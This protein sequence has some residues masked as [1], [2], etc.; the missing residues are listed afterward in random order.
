MTASDERP[1]ELPKECRAELN[2]IFA[3]MDHSIAGQVVSA[4]EVRGR[5]RL[6]L[7][8][9]WLGLSPVVAVALVA[10]LYVG[11]IG[12]L[13][14]PPFAVPQGMVA[15]SN[16]DA[17]AGDLTAKGLTA[18][19]GM[20]ALAA[21]S[22]HP[23]LSVDLQGDTVRMGV[24]ISWLRAS[25]PDVAAQLESAPSGSTIL[26]ALDAGEVRGFVS[27]MVLH[28]FRGSGPSGLLLSIQ[29]SS[30]AWMSI[31]QAVSNAI[32]VLR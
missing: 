8:A 2:A 18:S 29:S 17:G 28:G 24:L 27:L 23:A 4:I 25:H 26:L 31:L 9:L 14:T 21:R 22:T 20:A 13:T 1:F 3:P 5:H 11:G 10:V 12:L 7:Q 32:S 6:S 19:E 30:E 16:A 15:A